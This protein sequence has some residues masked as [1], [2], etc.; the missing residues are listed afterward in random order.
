MFSKNSITTIGSKSLIL[1]SNFLIIILTSVIWG[2]EGRGE[3]ALILADIAMIIIFNN[4]TSG[5]SVSFFSSKTNRNNLFFI[6]F[7]GSLIFSFLGAIFFSILQGFE[8]F[9][10]LFFISF[11]LSLSNS[12]SL[13]FL[14]KN[15]I[16]K[17]NLLTLLSP[18]LVLF[19]FL[20]LYYLFSK[21]DIQTAYYS[22]FLSYF[23]NLILG[24][25]FLIRQE[26][27]TLPQLKKSEIK[28]IIKYGFQNELSF[29]FQ[30]LNYRLSY[31][32]IDEFLGLAF[33]GVFSVAVALAEAIWIISKS[34]SAIHFAKILNLKDKLIMLK[35]T[36]QT[37]LLVLALTLLLMVIFLFVPEDLISYIFGKEFQNVK[38]TTILLF[39]GILAIAV[40]NIYGHY[41]SGIGK[42]KILRDKSILGFIV[43]ISF[44]YFLMKNYQL[45]GICYTINI[46]YIASSLFLLIKYLQEK[47][48]ITL[49]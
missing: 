39:P 32:V 2:A 26:K 1:F 35:E 46:S 16:Q 40:S 47:K 19:Y 24:L 20:I 27:I 49:E 17:Y 25:V 13:Y 38:S 43:T 33:L 5:S 37:S 18:V 42:M 48:D 23:S 7:L 14:G 15:E 29:F 30:F 9:Y 45:D 6:S 34:F 28:Q 44:L 12:I 36:K 11:F 21:R 31:F 8:N 4:I 10:F 3:I 22:Y 41:F